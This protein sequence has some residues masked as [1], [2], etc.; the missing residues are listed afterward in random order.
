MQALLCSTVVFAV[1]GAIYQRVADA[2]D[3]RR[4]HPPGRLVEIGDGR[5]MNLDC[6]GVGPHTVI[7][8]T[9]LGGPAVAWNE[10][11]KDLEPL[12][13]VCS[14]DR[15]GYVARR[16]PARACKTFD[17]LQAAYR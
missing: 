3:A 7:L 12:T 9:G 8:E 13:R 16:I 10:V 2:R 6:R 1:A 5:K 4:F 11:M 14:Y 15:A 17:P